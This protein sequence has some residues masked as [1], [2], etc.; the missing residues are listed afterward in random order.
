MNKYIAKAENFLS[1]SPL[2]TM[3]LYVIGFITSGYITWMAL[4]AQSNAPYVWLSYTIVMECGKAMSY[5]YYV[6]LNEKKYFYMWI[7]LTFFSIC[8]SMA[9]MVIEN[10]ITENKSTTSSLSYQQATDKINRIKEQITIKK[11]LLEQTA[12]DK[13]DSKQLVSEYNKSINGIQSTIDAKNREFKEA[14]QNKWASTQT[15][16]KNEIDQLKQKQNQDVKARNNLSVNADTTKISSEI[17][18][19][20][21]QL[22]SIDFSSLPQQKATSGFYALFQF[23]GFGTFWVE[24]FF[25]LALTTTFEVLICMLYSLSKTGHFPDLT[26]MIGSNTKSRVEAKSNITLDKPNTVGAIAKKYKIKTE[27]KKSNK[28]GFHQDVDKQPE[29]CIKSKVQEIDY[30]D[31]DVSNYRKVMHETK[32]K[33]GNAKGFRQI[34][35]KIGLSPKVSEKIHGHLCTTGEVEVIGG[36]TRIVKEVV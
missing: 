14:A 6:K 3:F 17:D 5:L 11:S 4:S 33:S 21:N 22:N 13:E 27:I 10:N 20:N 23:L 30:T 25:T 24:F 35:A 28:I 26:N 7:V 32:Y 16:I 2:V 15:R 8:A 1:S 18:G 36:R 34:G 12:K 31:E 9:F 29:V 19:L